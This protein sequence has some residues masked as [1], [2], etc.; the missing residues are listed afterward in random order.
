MRQPYWSVYPRWFHRYIDDTDID[1]KNG[2]F[3]IITFFGD[4]V[5]MVT[6][7]CKYYGIVVGVKLVTR[8][9]FF[10]NKKYTLHSLV[11]L[12]CFLFLYNSFQMDRALLHSVRRGANAVSQ[13]PRTV[14]AISH[15][16][17]VEV[18][19]AWRASPCP[20]PLTLVYTRI[21]CM[22]T[23]VYLCE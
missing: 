9:L 16:L 20:S 14:Q 2:G 22:G 11:H 3:G 10:N 7:I 21:I 17:Y 13:G 1:M 15:N 12:C 23:L 18:A 19:R 4:G 6:H 8:G 5:I